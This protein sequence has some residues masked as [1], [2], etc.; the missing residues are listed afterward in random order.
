MKLGKNN[1][2]DS[3]ILGCVYGI[4]KPSILPSCSVKLIDI[5]GQTV[6]QKPNSRFYCLVVWLFGWFGLFFFTT[7]LIHL[8]QQLETK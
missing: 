3:T 6:A 2:I 5:D 8:R 4:D 1:S 7:R